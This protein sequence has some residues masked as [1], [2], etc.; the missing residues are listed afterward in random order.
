MTKKWIAINLILLLGAGLL[1]WQLYASIKLFNQE[2]SPANLART[3]PARKKSTPD[4]GLPALQAPPKY[5]DAE[6]AIIPAQDLFA[7]SRK[8]AEDKPDV[9]PAL[10]SKTLEIKPVLLGVMVTGSQRIALISDPGAAGAPGGR[11]NQSLMLGDNYRGFVV[12][13]ITE[14]N[15]V[16][17]YGVSREVIPLY[18]TSKR[19]QSGKTPI[20]AT[21]V[22]NFGAAGAGAAGQPGMV[23]TAAGISRP[24]SP[25]GANAGARGNQAANANQSRAVVPVGQQGAGA[26][27]SQSQPQMPVQIPAPSGVWN[28][29]VDPQG[30]IIVN[31][32]FGAFPLPSAPPVKK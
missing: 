29:T 17:E 5:A 27:Q 23:V 19:A 10:E 6:F 4:G 25:P 32:P 16:L 18:D 11:R 20:L 22:V 28:Q 31:S 7:E 12:T 1:G 21:R 30:R 9:A 3:Q 15:M 8:L 13:D 24:P 2:N 14:N 26:G